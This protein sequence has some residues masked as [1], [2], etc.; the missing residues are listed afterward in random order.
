M[1]ELPEVERA[2]A[3]IAERG[4][5]RR[6]AD[7]DDTDGYVCRPHGP[8]EIQAA[9]VGREL[10][11]ANRIGKTMW[12]E[13]DDDGP[14]LGLHL[15]MAGRIYV[16]DAACGSSGRSGQLRQPEPGLGSL[17]DL[18]RGRRQA[19]PARQ[20]P[21]RARR[22]RARHLRARA[23]RGGDHPHRVP[24][25]RRSRDRAGQGA[26]DG[27]VGARRRRQPAG[28]RGAVAGED[29]AAAARRRALRRRSSTGCAATRARRS[30]TPCASA[31]CTTA[32]SWRS[33]RRAATA[34]AA[35]PRSGSRRSAGARRCGAPRSRRDRRGRRRRGGAA[36]R[37][38]PRPR[39]PPTRPPPRS[40]ART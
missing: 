2:R 36:G 30:A 38:R 9:L 27:P 34:R 26:A 5:H 16:D 14:E 40:R 3:L 7:V 24:R 21:A 11:T 35:E 15:G 18:L 29:L 1:P 32:S 25:A 28:R 39:R 19:D 20:A 22:A 10:V 23:R 13:T 4:L 12:F 8:G 6:I 31:A 37:A 33:A 17:H